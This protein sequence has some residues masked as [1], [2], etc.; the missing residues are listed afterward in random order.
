MVVED[1]GVLSVELGCR[2]LC[3]ASHP[4]GITDTCTERTSGRFDAR[5]T[6][7]RRRKLWVEGVIE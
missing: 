6:V 2:Q 3:S 1:L 4:H 5:S 7:L